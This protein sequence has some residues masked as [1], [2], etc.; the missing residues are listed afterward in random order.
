MDP[1]TLD[2]QRAGVYPGHPLLVALAITR[3]FPSLAVATSKGGT[4]TKAAE[5]GS[6]PGAGCAVWNGIH[7][8]EA[9]RDGLRPE[10]APAE[11][12]RRWLAYVGH[13]PSYADC[14]GPGNDAARPFAAEFVE[15]ARAWDFAVPGVKS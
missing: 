12:E 8:L 9:I 2:I 4:F 5:H 15:R 10:D 6:I 1:A 3:V 13:Q 7:L 11:A 14:V